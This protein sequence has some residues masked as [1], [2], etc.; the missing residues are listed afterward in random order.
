MRC[1]DPSAI[2]LAPFQR[3]SRRARCLATC[4]LLTAL[5][6]FA[7]KSLYALP[8]SS[9]LKQFT[10]DRFDSRSGL[11]DN[12]VMAIAQTTDGYLW[13][14]TWEGLARYNGHE[15]SVFDRDNTPALQRHAVRALAADAHGQL[16]VGT[17]RGGLARLDAQGGWQHW[18]SADGSL[19]FDDVMRLVVDAEQRVWVA[20]ET[21]GLV[22]IH[23]DGS[24]RHFTV[25]DGL[26][27]GTVFDLALRADGSLLVATFGGLDLIGVDDTIS[28][29][30]RAHGLPEGQVRA[31]AI[32]VA[33][34]VRASSGQRIYVL[35][36]RFGPTTR[37]NEGAGMQHF[38]RDRSG[39][40]WVA[41]SDRGLRREVGARVEQLDV[42]RGLAHNRVLATL[43]DREGN[44]WIGTAAGA[45]RLRHL[46]FATLG[47]NVGLDNRYVRSL[48]EDRQGALW[49]GTGGGLFRLD[50]SGIRGWTR[51]DGLPTE[52]VLSLLEVDNSLLIGTHGGGL[53]RFRD[54]AFD[55]PAGADGLAG[56]QVRA[57]L[58]GRDG[59]VWVGSSNGLYAWQAGSWRRFSVEHGLP[60]PYV[61]SLA[62]DAGG[63]LIVGTS[64]G[65]AVQTDSEAFSAFDQ[66]RGFPARDVFAIHARGND[67]VWF[68]TD[69]GIVRGRAGRFELISAA[70]GLPFRS[71]FTLLDDGR[72][73]VWLSSNRGILQVEW[74]AL[75]AAL[76][77]PGQALRYRHFDE[78]DG[79]AN[80]QANGGSQPAAIRRA[81]G[82][83]W[84]ATAEGAARI[85]PDPAAQSAPVS[86]LP[87]IESLRA[88]AQELA[89]ADAV[90][91]GSRRLDLRYVG[92]HFRNPQAVHYRHRL[93]GYEDDWID[94]G[95]SRSASYTNLP[96]GDYRFEL[97]AML[98]GPA[99][100]ASVARSFS[101]LP[102]WHQR[103]SVRLLGAALI[104]TLAALWLRQ[105]FASAVRAQAAL[106]ALVAERTKDLAA[107]TMRLAEADRE[108]SELLAQLRER[109]VALARQAGEDALTGLPNRRAFDAA[110]AEACAAR[111]A[112]HDALTL[113]LADVDHFKQIN[114]TYSHA[115]GDVV[116]QSLARQL[117]TGLPAG[118]L[119]ARV[120]GEE[121]ALLLPW[122][123]TDAARALCES[124]RA[125]IAT[126]PIRWEA[127]E[128]TV[129]VSFGLAEADSDRSTPDRLLR[130]ADAALY[131]AKRGGRNRV[132]AA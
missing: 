97:Q 16:W 25:D 27:N 69:A 78:F 87:R 100:A 116:L 117:V 57:L 90:P 64:D 105:R 73:S 113:V 11:P 99:S 55:L 115:A 132:E 26:A 47:S 124:V 39:A 76:D 18:H 119:V 93:I 50:A 92:L 131:R 38:H 52:A 63:R 82:S 122:Q 84:F 83:L 44:L 102:L 61:L 125:R 3:V 21:K 114:D 30:G 36:D 120:G 45:Q 59:V 12:M 95:E 34:R 49:L 5:C 43:E 109:S 65:I 86:P 77:T 46:P 31:V 60:R 75:E 96:P 35:A 68:A 62:F 56:T 51:D 32:D 33:G 28:A 14:G 20:S 48:L 42:S 53:I 4:A 29:F 6:L 107:Q 127:S 7:T 85:D 10:L 58:R 13:F 89:T 88:D 103:L 126:A 123:G 23:P 66:A 19:P 74:Q 70:Q 121:Y 1:P 106:E 101:I 67:T 72:E 91:A 128:I 94:A 22:R 54:G 130:A 8:A 71:W 129:T 9:T 40:L 111:Q 110:L 41:S 37:A 15:F 98:D 112:D 17:T 2:A 79:L 108:K 118:A 81:D 24:Q 80:R 104:V